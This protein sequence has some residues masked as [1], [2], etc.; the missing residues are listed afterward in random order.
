[1][2]L[3]YGGWGA[4]LLDGGTRYRVY[5]VGRGVYMG[6]YYANLRIVQFRAMMLG[7]HVSVYIDYMVMDIH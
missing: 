3:L 7:I 2:R 4:W 6:M 1:M 5:W